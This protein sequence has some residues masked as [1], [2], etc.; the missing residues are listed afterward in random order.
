MPSDSIPG[1]AGTEAEL[2]PIVARVQSA[3]LTWVVARGC[4]DAW[5]HLIHK[6]T[7]DLDSMNR[8]PA[9]FM[10]TEEAHFRTMI[11]SLYTLFDTY[12]GQPV[13][14]L[15]SLIEELERTEPAAAR[16]IRRR[17][18]SVRHEVRGKIE[19][20]RHEAIAHRT[21]LLPN[22]HVFAEAALTPD[23]IKILLDDAFEILTLLAKAVDTV[24]PYAWS[25]VTENT[26]DLLRAIKRSD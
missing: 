20:L 13:I 14:T 23:Q 22:K 19:R 4:Y 7:R 15:N 26:R 8:F 1:A 6:E 9:F 3:I 16:P 10:I 24:P 18:R 12:R 25:G 2:I 5:W 17:W 11:V 21:A